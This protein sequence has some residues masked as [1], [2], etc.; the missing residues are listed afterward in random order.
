MIAVCSALAG[1][2]S[3]EVQACVEAQIK[4]FD[5]KEA[6]VQSGK[7]S[8]WSRYQ[9]GGPLTREEAAAAAHLKCLRAAGR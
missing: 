2:G 3:D 9:A 5:T 1:C 4:A 6:Q 8:F 7:A